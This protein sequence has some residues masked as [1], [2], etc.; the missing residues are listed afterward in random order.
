MQ[1]NVGGGLLPM[2]MTQPTQNPSLSTWAFPIELHPTFDRLPTLECSQMWEGACSRWQWPSQ[3]KTPAKKNAPAC[4]PGHFLLSHTHPHL[5]DYPPW[6]A[7]KC[8]RELAPDGNGP[9]NTKRQAKKCPSLSTGAFLIE[10]Q[11]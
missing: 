6:N 3:H 8:R 11:P 10:L 5:T 4:R 9:A 2:A 7:V 1:S